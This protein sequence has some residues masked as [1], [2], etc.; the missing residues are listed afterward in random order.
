MK[1]CIRR[2]ELFGMLH[3]KNEFT[4]AKLWCNE[5]A[6]KLLTDNNLGDFRGEKSTRVDLDPVVRIEDGRRVF[7]G[8]RGRRLS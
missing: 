1:L 4:G 6:T 2:D 8:G 3:A 7:V 5:H